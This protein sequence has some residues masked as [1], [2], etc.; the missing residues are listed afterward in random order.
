VKDYRGDTLLFVNELVFDIDSFGIDKHFV[1]S[2][3]LKLNNGL[4]NI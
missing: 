4:M 1:D 2:R 3:L